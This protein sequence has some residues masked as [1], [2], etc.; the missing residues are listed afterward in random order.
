MSLAGALKKRPT[1]VPLAGIWLER[2]SLES[3]RIASFHRDSGALLPDAAH[4]DQQG[5]SFLLDFLDLRQLCGLRSHQGC[6]RN[7][8]GCHQVG[9][10]DSMG[11]LI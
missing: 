2:K 1:A 6:R 7:R 11:T 5:L 10:S 8:R 9:V 3:R 4:L